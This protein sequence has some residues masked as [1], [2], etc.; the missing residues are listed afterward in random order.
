MLLMT[1]M[2]DTSL[3]N[4]EVTPIE[5]RVPSLFPT[6]LSYGVQHKLLNAVQRLLEE[7]CFD[8][9]VKRTPDLV[10][11]FKWN[12]AE[13]VE[14]TQWPDILASQP[15]SLDAIATIIEPGQDLMKALKALRPLRHAAVHRIPTSGGE[16]EIML[17]CALH[18]V[19][20]LHDKVRRTKLENIIKDFQAKEQELRIRKH[21]LQNHL[22]RQLQDI[23]EQRAAL[24]KKEVQAKEN[25]LK[26]DLE[27]IKSISSLFEKSLA[28]LT[29]T[30][31]IKS[32]CGEAESDTGKLDRHIGNDVGVIVKG[33]HADDPAEK[34]S[35]IDRNLAGAESNPGEFE[36][37]ERKTVFSKNDT[38]LESKAK[39]PQPDPHEAEFGASQG[40]ALQTP[41]APRGNSEHMNAI[42]HEMGLDL[43]RVDE[44]SV[45]EIESV[46]SSGHHHSEKD[47]PQASEVYNGVSSPLQEI[48]R[49]AERRAIS[50]DETFDANIGLTGWLQL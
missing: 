1:I 48:E 12:C 9:A 41:G 11:Q 40:N 42:S 22:L 32:S 29:Q 23:E 10:A 36:V 46:Q 50:I 30:E 33:C 28:S 38:A 14:L 15:G 37:R 17:E 6:Y 19:R 4:E 2:T 44:S 18:L 49:A 21:Q 43:L 26:E 8:F 31:P 47:S 13:A 24:D 3:P 27:S 39:F 7:S 5:H 45:S 35:K 34:T 20:I 25:M 16:V